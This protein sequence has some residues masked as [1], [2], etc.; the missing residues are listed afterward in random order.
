MVTLKKSDKSFYISNLNY[1]LE[2][3]EQNGKASK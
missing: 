2:Q 3:E 1:K